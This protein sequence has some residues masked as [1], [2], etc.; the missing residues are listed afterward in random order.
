VVTIVPAEDSAGG[1]AAVEFELADRQRRLAAVSLRQE[2]GLPGALAFSRVA[3]AWR[4]RLPLPAVDRMEYLFEVEDHNG[5]RHTITDPANPR[6]APGAFGDKSVLELPAYRSPAWLSAEAVPAEDATIE[7]DAPELG[8]QVS[9]TLWAPST[10]KADQPAPL[11]VV[12]DGPEYAT[13]GG[14]THF[15]GTSIA[16]GSLPP[17]R[18]AL[19]DPGDR[20]DWYAANPAYATALCTAVLPALED[21]VPTT[22]RVGIGVS[23]GGLAMLHA[24]RMFPD[25]LDAMLLQSGS[26]FTPILDPQEFGFSG[27]GAVSAFTAEVHA[28]SN[29]ER[30][31]PTILTCGTVEENLENNAAMVHSLQLQGYPAELVL[32]RDAH[33]FTAWRDALDPNLTKLVADLVSAHAA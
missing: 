33:N 10:M 12:H 25:V 9:V 21:V 20:N 31:V 11:L 22:V 19:L 24:H 17:L 23:L 4:L 1:E 26:F 5:H 16:A 32:V 2:I 6:L 18:A 3:G 14:L 30:P 13:L 29:A 28:E 8:T 7:I 27:F 15:L